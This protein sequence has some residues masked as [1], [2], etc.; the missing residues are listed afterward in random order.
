MKPVAYLILLLLAVCSALGQGAVD[1]RNGAITFKNIAERR[2]FWCGQ[3]VL[4]TGTNYVAA[5]YYLPGA[6]QLARLSE[7]DAGILA[8]GS[9]NLAY[10]YFRSPTT[11]L[12]GV[13][14]NPF[15]VGTFRYLEGVGPGETATLQV[16]VWD[17][18]MYPDYRSAVLRGQY[19][20]STPFN[21]TVPPP[22]SPSEDYYMDNLRTTFTPCALLLSVQAA[23]ASV[24]LSWR[25]PESPGVVLEETERLGGSPPTAWTPVPFPYFTNAEQVSLTIPASDA[26]RFYRLHQR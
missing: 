12:P 7:P 22:G 4:L 2:V 13:W 17:I 10:A 1:F 14:L 15:P 21:Y 20:A 24:T 26:Q 11:S 6:D 8:R 3:S 5:L 19:Y 18:A 25:K 23:G 9:N 16:R